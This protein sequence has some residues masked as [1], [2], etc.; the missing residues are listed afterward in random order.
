MEGYEMLEKNGRERVEGTEVLRWKI[1]LPVFDEESAMGALYRGVEERAIAFCRGVLKEETERLFEVSEDPKKRFRFAAFVYRLEGRIV[2]CEGE[3][4]SVGL[5]ADLTRRGEGSMLWHAE[6]GHL[7]N[8]REGFMIPP[9]E[10]IRLFCKTSKKGSF[11]GVLLTEQ[12]LLL[13]DGSTWQ[14]YSRFLCEK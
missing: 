10:A 3:Y 2:W 9:K 4:L 14:E 12:S 13:W 1:C 11:D 8:V 7:W 6:D 5:R